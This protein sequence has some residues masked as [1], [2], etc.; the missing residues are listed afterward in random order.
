MLSCMDTYIVDLLEYHIIQC[1]LCINWSVFM[2]HSLLSAHKT[3][4][5]QNLKHFIKSMNIYNMDTTRRLKYLN[6]LYEW[7]CLSMLVRQIAL[8]PYCHETTY[9]TCLISWQNIQIHLYVF[10]IVNT[11][12]YRQSVSREGFF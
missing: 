3:M 5:P 6:S 7:M 10:N 8:L 12:L 1:S 2:T 9:T 11:N 4:S